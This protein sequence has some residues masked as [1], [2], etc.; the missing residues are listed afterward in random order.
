MAQANEFYSGVFA[1]FREARTGSRATNGEVLEIAEIHIEAELREAWQAKPAA[2]VQVVGCSA[3]HGEQQYA[4]RLA[5][6]GG[7]MRSGK[8]TDGNC[9][10]SVPQNQETAKLISGCQS[11]TSHS[12]HG[13][14]PAPRRRGETNSGVQEDNLPSH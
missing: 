12:L 10:F 4:P 2:V 8:S 7:E 3:T 1:T 6:Q 5:A 9:W 14:R 11:Q 13:R